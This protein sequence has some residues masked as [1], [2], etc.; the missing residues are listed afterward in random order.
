MRKVALT[1]IMGAGK[2]LVAHLLLKKGF[3]VVLADKLTHKTTAPTTNSYKKLVELLGPECVKPDGFLDRAKIASQIFQ[4]KSL[5]QKVESII[6]PVVWDAIQKKME[7]FS[8][9][10]A[11]IAFFEIPLLFEKNLE[12]FFDLSVV[13]AISPERQ[14]KLLMKNQAFSLSN[15]ACRMKY[16]LS[17]KQKIKKADYV[18]WNRSSVKALNLEL[19]TFLNQYIGS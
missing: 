14:K 12:P 18:I 6:H 19:E 2:S 13:I 4:K 7:D 8:K 11:T 1:G 10:S 5:L 15:I 16:Q 3:P 17:Q 9:K